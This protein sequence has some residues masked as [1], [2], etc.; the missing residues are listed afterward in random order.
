MPYRDGRGGRRLLPGMAARP[1]C[2]DRNPGRQQPNRAKW[3]AGKLLPSPA[4]LYNEKAH[5]P[6]DPDIVLSPSFPVSRV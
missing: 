5:R 3:E 4:I 6:A 1:G 2:G